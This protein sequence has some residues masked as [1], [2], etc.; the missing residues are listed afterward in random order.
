MNDQKLSNLMYDD[1]MKVTKNLE[2]KR[3]ESNK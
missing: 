1:I 2:N 3:L